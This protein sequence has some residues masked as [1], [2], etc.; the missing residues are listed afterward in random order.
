MKPT[1]P[2]ELGYYPGEILL[3]LA[4]FAILGLLAIYN[5]WRIESQTAKTEADLIRLEKLRQQKR[6]EIARNNAN[7]DANMER[8]NRNRSRFLVKRS[9][10]FDHETDA[11]R[12]LAQGVA[13]SFH[14]PNSLN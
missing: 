4:V 9:R 7:L 3:F 5:V 10:P 2:D 11:Q 12:A 13:D 6:A 8:L 1:T 14:A